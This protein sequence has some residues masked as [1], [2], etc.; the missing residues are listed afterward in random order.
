MYHKIKTNMK[1]KTDTQP[2]LKP[3]MQV[4][5]WQHDPHPGL[6]VGKRS[7]GMEPCPFFS[8]PS[9]PLYSL[10][11][12]PSLHIASLLFPSL[13]FLTPGF[14]LQI[15]LQAVTES[16]EHSWLPSRPVSDTL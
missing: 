13:P 6:K 14:P 11:S 12:L 3:Q 2:D 8:P 5:R 4:R 16:W 1:K 9:L 15:Q 10:L 7:A